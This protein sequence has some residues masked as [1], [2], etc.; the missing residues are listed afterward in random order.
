MDELDALRA[1]RQDVPAA[2][3]A[4]KQTA[5]AALEA[6]IERVEQSTQRWRWTPRRLVPLTAAVLLVIGVTVAGPLLGTRDHTSSAAAE[7]LN[8]LAKVASTRSSDTSLTRVLQGQYAYT[9]SVSLIA[10]FSV[11][12][13]NQQQASALVPV[14]REIWIGPDG[15][16]RIR[17][18]AGEPTPLAGAADSLQ[19]DYLTYDQTFAPGGLTPPL[20]AWGFTTEELLQLAEDPQALD[21]A[22]RAKAAGT[23]NPVEY[24]TFFVVG[25]MLRET[26]APSQLRAALYQVAA[27]IDGVEL[28]GATTDEAGRPG[29]AV[30]MTHAGVR[31]EL[32][33]DPETSALLGER[34][35]LVT[36]SAEW[37]NAPAGTVVGY[38]TYL[39]SAIVS[40]T[41]DAP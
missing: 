22:L 5:W 39:A 13:D 27:D 19:T 29:L 15:S 25:D 31:H 23:K 18:V 32:I 38:V 14:T 26:V 20:E 9:R 41:V 16:G 8:A 1:F 3:P 17:Q 6:R 34:D 24:E 4:A 7:E 37:G 21:A 11:N 33:F 10:N 35:V 40:S 36:P 28:L 30:A 12:V 2:C